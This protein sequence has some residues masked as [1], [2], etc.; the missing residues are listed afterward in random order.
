MPKPG[1]P[2]WRYQS[3]GKVSSS[4]AIGAGG[5][6]YVD[7]PSGKCHIYHDA[8]TES[9]VSDPFE[10]DNAPATQL[11]LVHGSM[12]RSESRTEYQSGRSS[13]TP[14]PDA[15]ATTGH[16]TSRPDDVIL[17]GRFHQMKYLVTVLLLVVCSILPAQEGARY[18]ILCRDEYVPAIRPLAEWKHATGLRTKIVPL[19][20][21]GADTASVHEYIL[22]A[23]TNWPV[24]PEY[25]LLVAH[26]SYMR[27]KIHGRGSSMVYS[28]NYFGDLA[29]DFRAEIPTGRFPIRSVTQCELM[30]AK[31][32]MYEQTPPLADSLWMRRL[33]TV[34]REDYDPP[35]DSIYWQNARYAATLARTNGFVSCDSLSRARYHDYNDVV[36]SIDNGTGIVMYRGSGTGN[37]RSPFNVNPAQCVNNNRLPIILSITCAMMALDPYD[38]MVGSAWVKTGTT[39]NLRGA[40]AFFGNTRLDSDVAPKRSAVARGFF[41]GLFSEGA[42]RIGNAM[43]RAKQQLYD[44]FPG[45]SVAKADYRG[46]NLFGDPALPIWTATP[47]RLDVN[48]PAQVR[49]EPQSLVVAVRHAGAPVPGAYVCASMDSTVYAFDSTDAT[50]R[51][52]L[53]IS[54][55]DTGLLRLVVT[56]RNLYPYDADIHVTNSSGIIATPAPGF[57][58]ARLNAF[59]SAF[60]TQTRLNWFAPAARRPTLVIRSAAG[61]CVRTLAASGSSVVW[62][63]LDDNGRPAGPGVYFAALTDQDHA[64]TRTRLTRLR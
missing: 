53:S 46:F 51:M 55:I 7:A 19:S 36:Q 10:L 21:V 44:E 16:W 61:R 1:N 37:W 62:N 8:L 31:T 58:P 32:L 45:D 52:E 24:R 41:N 27:A 60:T 2:A 59:P 63:G 25:V 42:Y 20:E 6:V 39:G 40:V 33:T 5:T 38:S 56:G 29:G 14:A 4:L 12:S 13:S 15:K 26:P 49:P 34:V 28:D 9:P 35:D 57:G 48:H 18:L 22:D 47:R 30:V 50:G 64:L 3:E 17:S 43:L 54:P 23:W 11:R